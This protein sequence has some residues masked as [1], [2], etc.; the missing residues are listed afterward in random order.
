MFWDQRLDLQGFHS[1][2]TFPGPAQT[3]GRSWFFLPSQQVPPPAP[4]AVPGVPPGSGP[5]PSAPWL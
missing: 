4:L 3:A 1:N 5:H 2:V